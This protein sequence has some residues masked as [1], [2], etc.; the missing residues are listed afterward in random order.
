MRLAHFVDAKA[1]VCV[2]TGDV[3]E[4]SVNFSAASGT[5]RA[6][7]GQPFQDDD[8]DALHEMSVGL[9]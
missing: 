1:R 5:V 7:H 2:T 4:A 9:T 8:A 3:P 6:G